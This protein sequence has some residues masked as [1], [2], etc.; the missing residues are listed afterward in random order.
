M[1]KA[2]D[3]ACEP[4]RGS[5]YSSCVDLHAREEISIKM[6]DT[7]IAPLGVKIDL[8]ALRATAHKFYGDVVNTDEWWDTFLKGH[9][10]ELKCR[11]SF[12]LKVKMIVGNG[13]GEIDI[14]YP[15]EIGLILY[16]PYSP[17]GETRTIKKGDRIAQIKL[18]EHKSFLMGVH[19]E[20]ERDGGFGSTVDK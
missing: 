1:F 15:D 10:L 2:L 5:K 9:C 14:D 16:N 17:D 8:E 3:E 6:G 11:S 7:G 19:S 13:V 4:T 20:D 12:P 18:V